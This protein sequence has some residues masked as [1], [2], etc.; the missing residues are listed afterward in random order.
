MGKTPQQQ[1]NL[2]GIDFDPIVEFKSALR[3]GT[4]WDSIVDFATHPSFCGQ[5]LYPRQLTLLKLIY[6][7]TEHMTAFDLEV[8][9]EWRQGFKRKKD[10]YGVQ[11]DIWDRVNYLK[12]LGFRHF[13]HIEAVIGRR[14]SKGVIGGILGAE[15]MAYFYSLDNWQDY[16]GI[17]PGKDGYMTVVATNSIQ[18]KKFQF[19]DIRDVI[20]NCEYLKPHLATNKDDKL[21]IRTPADLRRLARMKADRIPI[22]REIASLHVVAMS[23][24]SSSGRGATGFANFY[25]EFAHMITGT[26]GTRSSEEVYEAYQPSLDQFGQDSLTY[27]PSSPYC[28]A[29]G[30]RVLKEDL[31][32]V[33]VETLVV[34]DKLVGFDE[35]LPGGKGQGR[36]WRSSEVTETS[37]ITAPRFK[38]VMSD[39]TEVLSTGEHLWLGRR[40]QFRYDWIK[41]KD[42]K[43]GDTIKSL[44]VK[45][46]ETDNTRE[47]GYLAGFYDGEGH[48]GSTVTDGV[49]NGQNLSVGASQNLGPV[50][51]QV[52]DY[53][54]AR[55]FS[56]LTYLEDEHANFHISGGFPESL[57]FLGSIRPTRLLEKFPQS[58]YGGRIYSSKNKGA[59]KV[60]SIEPYDTGEVVALGTSTATLVAEGL[61]S[62]NTQVGKMFELYKAGCVTMRVYN[63]REGIVESITQTEKTLDV[64]AE[65]ELLDLTA[66]PEMLVVQLP[67]WEL[68]R[69]WERSPELGGHKFKG[70][71]QVLNTK[72]LRIKRRNPEKFKVE[73]EAQFASVID[74]Y[75]D[76]EKVDEMFAQP[77]WD[78]RILGPQDHGKLKYGYRIHVDPGLTNANFA[79]T[80]AHLE[81]AP[82]DEFGDVWP[83]VIIDY[84][85]VWKPGDYKDHTVPYPQIQKEIAELLRR[86]PSTIKLSFDQ[87]NS[88]GMIAAL[89]EEFFPRIAIE[90]Q[91][92]TLKT[93]RDRCENFKSAMNLGWVHAYRDDFFVE[94]EDGLL[95]NELKFLQEKNGQVVKQDFGP[96]T[97]KDLADTVMEVTV[98]LLHRQLD[99][100]QR[101]VMGSGVTVGQTNVDRLRGELAGGLGQSMA[102]DRSANS[103]RRQIA[104]NSLDRRRGFGG[105]VGRTRGRGR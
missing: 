16:Y 18:A 60:V 6:L 19:A 93:N 15:K 63:E 14:G 69:D 24:N 67:S 61:L 39:G 53:L 89:R 80:I 101:K 29:P 100:W 58:L 77:L 54:E 11:P 50:Y 102:G 94:N 45:P 42:I 97:T 1:S 5:K 99:Q 35:H 8:I 87:W 7:E 49:K 90:V 37:I 28:L 26:G 78:G 17:K 2:V 38:M 10:M 105:S 40:T 84:M 46:W 92:F 22:E 20:E 79:L 4:K 82:P 65:E 81:D 76:P 36:L 33:G 85:K 13:P 51:D 88:A 30:T 83:H 96:V 75:L 52:Q 23:S 3:A 62:H 55:G 59:L 25:D 57:R 48:L 103:A 21:A 12:D 71:I 104:Q 34:G 41:T 31:T 66:D 43:V 74:A 47:G 72:M 9:E 95:S 91:E 73:R 64:D 44:G 98:S 56:S 86:F 32:W 68:Y 27:I 70:P